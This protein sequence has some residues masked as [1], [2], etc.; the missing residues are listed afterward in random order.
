MSRRSSCPFA[1]LAAVAGLVTSLASA[2]CT[3][4]DEPTPVAVPVE[5]S[6]TWDLFPHRL[7]H[8]ELTF[9]QSSPSGGTLAARMD[10]GGWGALDI[11]R[12]RYGIELWRSSALRAEE[13]SVEIE[14]PPG[15]EDDGELHA[16]AAALSFPAGALEGKNR[17]H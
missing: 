11:P 16:V 8:Q 7:S 2:G 15:A 5:L 9:A 4:P 6:T 3:A 12:V 10:G 13:A 1:R 17:L 14:I